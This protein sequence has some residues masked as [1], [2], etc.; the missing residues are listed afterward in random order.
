MISICIPIYNVDVT[1]LVR[2]L[3]EQAEK[4]SV[5]YE[6]LLID[7]ASDASFRAI[8]AAIHYPCVRYIPLE[9]NIGRSGIRNLLADESKYL[10]LI[11]MDCDSE[12]KKADY[13]EKYLSH[14]HS[15]V[16]CYG[17][18]C[19]D[20]TPPVVACILHWKYGT[21]REALSF[22]KRK[23]TPYF[24]FQTNNF[25]ID[26][27]IFDVVRFN[28]YISGYG[29]EDTLIGIDFEN[30]NILVEHVDNPLIHNGLET[31]A[32]F[33]AKTEKGLFN[34][35]KIESILPPQ[36]IKTFQKIRIV[37]MKARLEKWHLKRV[38][39]FVYRILRP[40]L[41]LN[42]QGKSPSLIAFDI[43]KLGYYCRL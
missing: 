10:Y 35:K 41:L 20:A 18:R 9:S 8:N 27:Q 43:Y 6:I 5:A 34:L 4:L 1:R 21:N 14:C 13:L 40:L 42:L 33:L 12:V 37:R 11:F 23:A 29:H 17:G 38:F 30:N 32:V 39:V 22:E 16:V 26:K 7:D 36:S 15:G 2:D 24:A 31:S 19:Y 28:E 3:Y 25:L